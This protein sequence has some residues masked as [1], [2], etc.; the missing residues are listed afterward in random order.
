MKYFPIFQELFQSDSIIF[1]LIGL[2]ITVFIGIKLNEIKKI[3]VCLVSSV[4]L[5]AVCELISNIHTNYLFE[6]ILLFV[7]TIAIGGI[8]G[9]LISAIVVKIRK[10]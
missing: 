7:G 10:Q 5:Y 8:I 1:M 9:F 6:L 2:A 4:A 3:I